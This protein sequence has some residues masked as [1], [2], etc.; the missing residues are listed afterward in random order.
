MTNLPEPCDKCAWYGVYN[1]VY[2]IW[3]CFQRC[4]R[5]H[6]KSKSRE[7]EVKKHKSN[8]G[9]EGMKSM[10]TGMGSVWMW[11]LRWWSVLNWIGKRTPPAPMAL[12]VHYTIFLPR[13][14][15]QTDVRTRGTNDGTHDTESFQGTARCGGGSIKFYG[16][17]Q[18]RSW[19]EIIILPSR[20]LV[21]P[22]EPD[23]SKPDLSQG[24][25]Q[26]YCPRLIVYQGGQLNPGALEFWCNS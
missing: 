2:V 22:H 8:I 16:R 15:A 9:K 18:N 10:M 19:A 12:P 26:W 17:I 6:R 23:M 25:P 1:C 20:L 7:T 24:S 3:V 14:P 11:V 21:W 4:P 13:F 5:I